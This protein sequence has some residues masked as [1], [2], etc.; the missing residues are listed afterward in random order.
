MASFCETWQFLAAFIDKIIGKIW[1][2]KLSSNY[3]PKEYVVWTLIIIISFIQIHYHLALG[4]SKFLGSTVLYKSPKIFAM[5][6][7]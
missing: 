1:I 3:R 4:K 5:T 6:N 7:I 2:E